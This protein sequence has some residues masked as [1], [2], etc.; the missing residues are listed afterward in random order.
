MPINENFISPGSTTPNYPGTNNPVTHSFDDRQLTAEFDDALVDQKAWKNSRYDGSK[1]TAAKINKFTAGDESYQN[2][3]T[4]LK[5]TTALYIADSIIGGEEDNNFTTIKNHSYVNISKILIIDSDTNQVQLIDK[6]TEPF[7]EFQRFVTSDFETGTKCTVKLIDETPSDLQ[8]FHRVKMNKGKLLKSFAFNFA[9]ETNDS[10]S[11]NDILTENNSIYFY[12]S[13]SF[14]D[15]VARSGSVSPT[16]T[17][18]DQTNALRL[19]YGVIELFDAQVSNTNVGH[20]FDIRRAGPSFASSSIHENKFTQQY[21][22]GAF[23]TILHQPIDYT[24]S[25][26]SDTLNASGLGS[27]S[28]FLGIDTLNFLS[29]NISDTSLTQQEKT[30]V[31]ITFFKG[32]KDFAPGFNDERSIGTFE[33]DQNIGNLYIQEGDSCNGGLPTNHE[34]IFKGRDDGRFLP[35]LNTF[36]DT[37]QNAHLE[38]S[39]VTTTGTLDGNGCASFGAMVTKSSADSNIHSGV[40]VLGTNV[41]IDI[42]ESIQCYVQGGALGPIGNEGALSGSVFTDGGAFGG[43]ADG[44]ITTSAQGQTSQIGNMTIDNFYSGSFDY[45]MSFLDKDH[46]LILDLNKDVELQNGIGS[47]GVIIIPET[48]TSQIAN[49]IEFYLAQ[50][51]I[52]ENTVGLTQNLNYSQTPPPGAQ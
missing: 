50:A 51:G 15:N 31:H 27:A 26:N 19:R 9:G 23:G 4:L 43:S 49:N 24:A 36:A 32:T 16:V 13:G 2:Q 22:S 41:T 44:S 30:E 39:S 28:R 7:T 37:I 46:T 5:Q 12:K 48:A 40:S 33:V 34:L 14:K 20:F 10:S 45:E 35:T 29:N 3:P 52:V 6:A 18:I 8:N 21:Y 25:S 42:I 11:F 38:S 1:L 17:G 47:N